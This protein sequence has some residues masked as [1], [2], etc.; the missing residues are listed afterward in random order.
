MFSKT[1]NK[2]IISS[3]IGAGLEFYDFFVFGF[4]APTIMPLFIPGTNS[5]MNMFV[6]HS[7]FAIG[8]FSRP[9]GAI[10]FG[11]IGDEYGRK[12]SLT[13]SI[14]IM[15]LATCCIGVL[16]TYEHIGISAIVLLIIFRLM[17]GIA[18]G[19]ESPGSMV[20]ACEHAERSDK[21]KAVSFVI[22]GIKCGAL[23]AAIVI[24]LYEIFPEVTW[25]MAFL[26]G[27]VTSI[28]GYMIRVYATDP[29]E[30]IEAKK[31]NSRKNNPLWAFIKDH[32]TN[33]MLICVCCIFWYGCFVMNTIFFPSYIKQNQIFIPSTIRLY[34]FYGSVVS[35][36]STIASGYLFA[37]H[38]AVKLIIIATLFLMVSI[39]MLCI[40]I[41]NISNEM[42][43]VL[44][45]IYAVFNGLL[46]APLLTFLMVSVKNASIRFSGYSF[47]SSVGISLAVTLPSISSKLINLNYGAVL[48]S[49]IMLILG[50]CNILA[51]TTLRY[52]DLH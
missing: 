32:P 42:F 25:R 35:I 5:A 22:A 4:F 3:S 33:M 45:M 6:G 51:I 10:I 24:Y 18:L 14:F 41:K 11:Y 26:L 37:V 47:A 21:I 23:L 52:K 13:C 43:I 49:I 1:K 28:I 30:F 29:E 20:F 40:S 2:N 39:T 46:A 8:Y 27:L 7:L 34:V 19:G 38:Q 44:H 36:I 50:S 15:G 31:K 12:T 17:Q 16:P 9:I 48:I